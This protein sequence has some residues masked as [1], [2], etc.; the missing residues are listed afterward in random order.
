MRTR[1]C[2]VAAFG[3]RLYVEGRGACLCQSGAF[4][5]DT[6]E[7][8][9]ELEPGLYVSLGFSK[10]EVE[11]IR[12]KVPK[13]WLEKS[14]FLSPASSVAKDVASRLQFALE[15]VLPKVGRRTPG[16]QRTLQ[17]VL[18]RVAIVEEHTFD[19]VILLQIQWYGRDRFANDTEPHW[20]VGRLEKVCAPFVRQ[21]EYNFLMEQADRYQLVLSTVKQMRV[22]DLLDGLPKSAAAS[23]LPS[24]PCLTALGALLLFRVVPV[25]LVVSS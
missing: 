18:C 8:L 24:P 23:P 2:S 1:R 7:K 5:C 15:R 11:L 19:D 14:G 21:L 25:L 9:V 20:H 22:Y 17:D 4:I 3:E 10:A 6:S 13:A 16:G 12:E